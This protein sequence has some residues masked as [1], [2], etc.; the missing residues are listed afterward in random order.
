[1][2]RTGLAPALRAAGR[3]RVAFQLVSS[4]KAS[5]GGG[6]L[7]IP[8]QM[9]RFGKERKEE[10][11]IGDRKKGMKEGLD[12][13]VHAFILLLVDEHLLYSR[14]WKASVLGK[15]SPSYKE[16]GRQISR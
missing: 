15:T 14:P 5:R 16:W 4:G 6:T 9:G 7:A 10:G 2:D 8:G 1:M 13:R 3:E 12:E 11:G